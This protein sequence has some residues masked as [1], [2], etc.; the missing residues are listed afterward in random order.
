MQ[1]VGRHRELNTLQT[2]ASSPSAGL[3]ILY[4]RRRI[5][6]TRLVTHFLEQNDTLNTFYWMATT[7]N[8]LH[9][10]RDFSHAILAFDPRFNEP[11]PA[12]YAFSSWEAALDHLAAVVS[13]SASAT[14]IVLD[15]FTYLLRNEPAISSVFQKAWDHTLSKI[16]TLKL[17]LTGSLIGMLAR[18]VFSYQ[19]PLYGR[20][21]AQ[22]RLQPLPFGA[23]GELFPTRS[24]AEQVAIYGITGGVP[25]YLD[26]FTR[27]PDFVSALHQH[28]LADGSIFLSDPPIIIYEQLSEPQMY[29]SVL[30][31][32][33]SGFHRWS[34]I[35][36]M[37]GIKETA[38]SH[39]LKVLQELA[40]I[41]RRQPVPTKPGSK[42]GRYYITDPFL[43]FYYRFI[44]PQLGALARGYQVAVAEKI[45]T[46]LRAFLGQHTFEELCREW[47]WAAAMADDFPF[48]PEQV[49][50]FWKPR[51]NKVQLDVVA[52]AP[53]QKRLLVGECKWGLQPVGRS[54]LTSLV[55]RS[56]RMPQIAA[57]WHVDYVLFA[58]AGFT[59]ALKQAAKSQDVRLVTLD[60]FAETL[61]SS[62]HALST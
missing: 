23:L 3:C 56:Q 42:S 48:V 39:Y 4:G 16:P 35:A 28:C 46:E 36:K 33:A 45:Q 15:E 59:D 37:V 22:I 41:E 5:G 12:D 50:S 17:I 21:T 24:I 49:G 44:V 60:D 57:G 10:L 32:I 55:E 26:L 20:A 6:K 61:A 18:E 34:D 1:F 52:A 31:T 19:A 9:Q 62:R 58:R 54:V 38:L 27:T 8:E 7:H 30:S 29:E 25:A 47:V 51:G 13:A 2:F 11:P 40:F 43:R 53:R 14:V